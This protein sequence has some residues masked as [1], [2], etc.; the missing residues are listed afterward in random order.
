MTKKDEMKI[1]YDLL[2]EQLDFLL[3]ESDDLISIEEKFLTYITLQSYF[4]SYSF[5]NIMMI[6]GQYPN[7]EFV[8][9]AEKWERDYRR[10]VRIGEEPI[11]VFAPVM[12]KASK[13]TKTSLDSYNLND[14]IIIE[15]HIQKEIFSNGNFGT[16]SVLMEAINGENASGEITIRGDIV[17]VVRINKSYQFVGN[18]GL[19]AKGYKQLNILDDGVIEL[20]SLENSYEDEI[21]S[22]FITTYVYDI[23]QTE[24][25]SFNPNNDFRY[26]DNTKFLYKVLTTVIDIPIVEIDDLKKQSMFYTKDIKIILKTGLDITAKVERLLIEYLSYIMYKRNQKKQITFN[27]MLTDTGRDIDEIKSLILQSA[28]AIICER[29]G[30]LTD[31]SYAYLNHFK[32]KDSTHIK[33]LGGFIQSLSFEVIEQIEALILKSDNI[34]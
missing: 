31:F 18:I 20:P 7:A 4:P 3:D 27:N 5:N 34:G 14:L 13:K 26:S 24:G 9:S 21:L 30:I 1:S 33:A 23:S 2:N 6:Y 29:F 19:N 17:N 10:L 25:D 12:K 32:G 16:F 8:A 15:G 28:V 11:R 22:H